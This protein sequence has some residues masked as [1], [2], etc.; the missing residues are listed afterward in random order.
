MGQ[1]TLKMKW[2]AA[3][4]NIAVVNYYVWQVYPILELKATLNAS[5]LT[6]E[7]TGLNPNTQYQFRLKADD[8]AGN[9]SN[10]SNEIT[11]KTL[12]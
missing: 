2:T 11:C 1:T 9:M 6:Y 3:T 10:Y 12:A 5:T 4:D 7:V 8:A